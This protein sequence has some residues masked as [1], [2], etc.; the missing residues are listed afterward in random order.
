MFRLYLPW[1]GISCFVLSCW[2]PRG[3]KRHPGDKAHVSSKDKAAGV[4][5]DNSVCWSAR[6]SM[7]WSGV[8]RR[9]IWRACGRAHITSLNSTLPCLFLERRKHRGAEFQ[10]FW[11]TDE[12]KWYKKNLNSSFSLSSVAWDGLC[13]LTESTGSYFSTGL[14]AYQ[15]HACHARD[16][17]SEGGGLEGGGLGP[18]PTCASSAHLPP[19]MGDFSESR[20]P[21]R[22]FCKKK[23]GCWDRIKPFW[24]L[25]LWSDASKEA[26]RIWTETLATKFSIHDHEQRPCSRD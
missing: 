24:I 2:F 25:S 22:T 1:G 18:C 16:G 7:G 20:V 15:H 17:D 5:L 13:S 4:H 12:E 9:V 11:E 8:D 19:W 3:D 26:S 14:L 23:R 10:F 21:A 6:T